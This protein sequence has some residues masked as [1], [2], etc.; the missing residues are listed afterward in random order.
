MCSPS[1]T[2]SRYAVGC[3]DWSASR[4][5]CTPSRAE[6]PNLTLPTLSD[7]LPTSRTCC[8]ACVL[9]WCCMDQMLTRASLHHP[10]ADQAGWLRLQWDTRSCLVQEPAQ[11]IIDKDTAATMLGITMGHAPHTQ[12]FVEFLNEQTEYKTINMDQWTGFY[13]FSQEVS[14]LMMSL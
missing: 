2:A 1:D 3:R 9:L 8:K 4:L 6:L 11:K 13:R 12:P 14:L 7:L 5:A 10:T